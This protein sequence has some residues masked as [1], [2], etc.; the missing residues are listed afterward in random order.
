MVQAELVAASELLAVLLLRCPA[1]GVCASSARGCRLAASARSVVMPRIFMRVFGYYS[2][3]PLWTKG[4]S[5]RMLRLLLTDMGLLFGSSDFIC[6]ASNLV[7]K[8]NIC[9]CISSPQDRPR[10]L[11]EV[12]RRHKFLARRSGD[13]RR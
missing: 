1:A 12:V 10:H 7:S 13:C 3:T 8:S 11:V 9:P 4:F 5:G 2:D 6:I